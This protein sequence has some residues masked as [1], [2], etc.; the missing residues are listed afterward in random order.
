MLTTACAVCKHGT[1]SNRCM[2]DDDVIEKNGGNFAVNA[3][4]SGLC[5][6]LIVLTIPSGSPIPLTRVVVRMYDYFDNIF[7][8]CKSRSWK[9]I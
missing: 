8:F 2:P 5:G 4:R 7:G 3:T 9:E 1:P 6:A